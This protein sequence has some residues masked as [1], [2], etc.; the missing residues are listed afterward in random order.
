MPLIKNIDKKS[1]AELCKELKDLVKK[2]QE[3]TLH[4]DD[5]TSGTFTITN[6]GSFGGIR[7]RIETVVINQPESAILGTG[8]I[9]DKVVVRNEKIVI[10]SILT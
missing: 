1:L 2:V 10:R 6:F 5:V 8:G 9:S 4:H 7:Y 3:G